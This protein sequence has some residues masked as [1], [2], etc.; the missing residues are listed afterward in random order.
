MKKVNDYCIATLEN[1]VEYLRM[2]LLAA[3]ARADELEIALEEAGED[4]RRASCG[5]ISKEE[6]RDIYAMMEDRVF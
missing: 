2:Q 6:L 3:K 1:E 5:Q 4:I